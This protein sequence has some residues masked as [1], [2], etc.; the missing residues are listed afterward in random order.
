MF[1][2]PFGPGHRA[3]GRVYQGLII[4]L[5]LCSLF[6][7]LF[8]VCRQRGSRSA[9][10]DLPCLLRRRHLRSDDMHDL[11][12][13]RCFVV[14]HT[15]CLRRGKGDGPFIMFRRLRLIDDHCGVDPFEYWRSEGDRQLGRSINTWYKAQL[16]DLFQASGDRETFALSPAGGALPC[17]HRPSPYPIL[18]CASL[19]RSRRWIPP[20]NL[21]EIGNEA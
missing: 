21:R 8:Q 4:H 20:P 6:G 19:L 10:A 13:D 11:D 1:P 2:L 7:R 5:Q 18:N 9:K 16:P 14:A 12:N 17:H 15:T 3:I